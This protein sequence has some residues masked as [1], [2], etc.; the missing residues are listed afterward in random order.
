[1]SKRVQSKVMGETRTCA[2]DE[3][4]T[5]FSPNRRD[6]VYCCSK[7]AVRARNKRRYTF[8]RESPTLISSVELDVDHLGDIEG[9]LTERGLVP[10]EWVI[11]HC[12]VN[13]WEGFY[14][15]G[16]KDNKIAEIVPLKQLKV[17]LRRRVGIGLA[18]PTP[19]E[20]LTIPAAPARP[21][22]SSKL[23]FIYGDDQRPNVDLG[24][25]QTKLDW[26]ARHQPD[27]IVDL[28]DGMDFPTLSGHKINPAMNWSVNECVDN[29]TLWL[30]QLRCAAPNAKI[31]ILPDNH[32]TQRLRDYQL[33]RAVDLYGL[34]PADLP[35]MLPDLEPLLSIRRMLRLDE[36][37]IEYIHPPNDTHYAEGQYEIVPGDLVALHGY[38]TG[39]NVGK[40]LIDDYG[41]SVIYGHVHEHS[42]YATD[43][44]R[45]GVGKRKRLYALGVGCGARVHG[46]GDFAPGA[47]WQNCALT[48]SV[49]ENGWTYDYMDFEHGILR[50]R[51]EE[52][53]AE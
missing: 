29:Y 40:K 2:L 33:S 9:L 43:V 38:R 18:E 42:V 34:R 28:G 45:R 36:L 20:K 27:V 35:G 17:T 7:H 21:S 15:T 26:V 49:F 19:I 6:Q 51:D 16:P 3:C 32:V 41:C 44:R 46:G 37:N 48:V 12:V 4:T 5:E 22:R 1:M 11:I 23:Y 39:A 8:Q 52:Y 31:T 24:F 30:Y 50:W 25:E 47:D 10:S 13:K 14:K 53:T